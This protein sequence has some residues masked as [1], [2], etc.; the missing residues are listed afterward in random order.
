M[1]LSDRFIRGFIAGIVGGIVLDILDVISNRLKIDEL[2]YFDWAGIA[3]YGSKPDNLLE[4]I[5]AVFGQLLL[6]G[7]LGIVFAY[8][9]PHVTSK[10]IIIKGGIFGLFIWFAF[11]VIPLLF[12]INKLIETNADSAASDAVTG[13]V[14]GVIVAL[15]LYRLDKRQKI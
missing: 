11:F 9:I 10:N 12:K 4:W 7:F 14:Y 1:T 8:F 6:T 15:T 5:V 2:T 3:I 13:F